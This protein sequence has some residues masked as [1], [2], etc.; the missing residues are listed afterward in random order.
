MKRIMSLL[1]LFLCISC[2]TT[3]KVPM[4]EYDENNSPKVVSIEFLDT[5]TIVKMENQIRYGFAIND[6][7]VLVTDSMHTS[8]LRWKK[9]LPTYTGLYSDAVVRFA[10]GFDAVQE[11]TKRLDFIEG[12]NE[13]DYRIWGLH[14]KGKQLVEHKY[15][16]SR[17]RL[18]NENQTFLQK[19]LHRH[20][21]KVIVL[22][23]LDDMDDLESVELLK[24]TTHARDELT[25]DPH[26]SFV[27]FSRP[28]RKE[29]KQEENRAILLG[30]NPTYM[31][32][33]TSEDYERLVQLVSPH[34]AKDKTICFDQTLRIIMPG[35]VFNSFKLLEKQLDA[36]G[37]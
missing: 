3:W 17:I 21:G 2:K 35:L 34:L 22:Q 16:P 25:G 13:K 29:H 1:I 15:N 28:N 10:L 32:S 12:P 7:S 19:L 23:I 8:S 11:N 26:I 20:L 6:A 31:E 4:I 27:T 5:A 14:P 30:K 33:V 18:S 37:K 36:L 24:R 9:D